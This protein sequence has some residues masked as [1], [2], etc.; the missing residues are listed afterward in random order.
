M[1]VGY[2]SIWQHGKVLQLHALNWCSGLGDQG[3]VTRTGDAESLA[4]R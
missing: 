3:F 2:K 1:F 4:T